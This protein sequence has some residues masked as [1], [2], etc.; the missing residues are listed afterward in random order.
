MGFS[1]YLSGVKAAYQ[2]LIRALLPNLSLLDRTAIEN[3]EVTLYALRQEIRGLQVGQ[4][5]AQNIAA[6]RGRHG[7]IIRAQV[8]H[9]TTYYE[10]FPRAAIIRARP[11]IKTLTINGNV[12]VETTGGSSRSGKGT[13]G[14]RPPCR[15]TGKPTN[16]AVVLETVSPAW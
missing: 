1:D 16:T 9:R 6:A 13:F 2:T 15:S 3:G 11:D 8:K 12:V 14:A 7:F 4:E 5:N 10:V